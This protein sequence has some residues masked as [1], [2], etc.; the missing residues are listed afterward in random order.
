[1][2]LGHVFHQTYFLQ[3]PV[4]AIMT[5]EL[6]F[7]L[8]LAMLLFKVLVAIGLVDEKLRATVGT[9]LDSQMQ[10]NAAHVIKQ[11]LLVPAELFA[12]HALDPVWRFPASAA[13]HVL[14]VLVPLRLGVEVRRA[15]LMEI[16]PDGD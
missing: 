14:H 2:F 16:A 12:V 10:M 11:M 9:A 7:V 13:M 3:R 4:S 8:V 15:Q 5:V 1:M 6:L